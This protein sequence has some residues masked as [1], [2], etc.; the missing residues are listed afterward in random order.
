MWGTPDLELQEQVRERQRITIANYTN[1]PDLL[2]E[3]VGM[4]DNFQAGGYGERQIEELLQNAIDRLVEP[5]R[6]EFRLANSTLYC[7]N[8]GEPFAAAG[9]RAVTGAFLS[10]KRDEQIGRFGL[11]FKSV[12]GVTDHPQI[13]SR[14]VSFGFNEPEAAELFS[15]LPYRP[16]RVPT[17][18]VPSVIDARASAAEDPN[19]A[20]MM[21]WATTIVRLPL[22]RGGVRLRER[23]KGFDYRYL[24]F[25]DRLNQVVISLGERGEVV[26]RSYRKTVDLDAGLVTLNTPDGDDGVWRV[27]HREHDISRGVKANLP[28]LFHRDRVR[29][30]YALPV[31]Q[32]RREDGE[33]WAWFPLLDKTTAQGIFNAPWQV[34]DDRTSLLPRSELNGEMLEVA[35]ELLIDAATLE[36]TT[37]DPAKHF[38]VLPARGREV[39][40]AAD[41]YMSGRV[42]RLAR[43]HQLIPTASGEM[44]SPARVRAPFV[45]N[46]NG[47]RSFALP[48]EAIR[49]WSEATEAIDTPH[50]SCYQ[51]PTRAAR[52]TQLLSDED[53]KLSATPIAP[54]AWLAEA[55]APRTREAVDAALTIFLKLKEQQEQIWRQFTGALVVPLGSGSM[56]RISDLDKILLPV[57]GVPSPNVQLVAPTFASD[58]VI[59]GKLLRLGVHEVSRDQVAIAAAMAANTAWLDG[60]WKHFW[61]L[62]AQASPVAARTAIESIR[63]RRI[64]IRVP[65]TAGTWKPASQVFRDASQVP[66]LPERHVDLPG[67]MGRSDLLGLAGCLSG[68]VEDWPVHEGAVFEEYRAAMRAR[69]ERELAPEYGRNVRASVRFGARQGSGP[70]DILKEL[71]QIRTSE[72]DLARARL[73]AL[74]CTAMPQQQISVLVDVRGAHLPLKADFD[75]VE[76][77]CVRQYGLFDSTW[78]ARKSKDVLARA[79][80]E[81]GDLLP[82]LRESFAGHLTLP[83]RLDQIPTAILR[84]FL[85]RGGYVLGSEE[86]LGSVLGVAAARPELAG[87]AAI[88][89]LEIRSNLVQVTPI[90]QVVIAASDELEDLTSH[91]LRYI[92]SGPWDAV[93]SNAWGVQ[94]AADVIAR[95]TDWDAV[96]DAVPVPDVYPTL[97]RVLPSGS[98]VDDVMLRR[99]SSIVRRTTSPTGS[100]EQ[101]LSGHVDGHTVLVDADLSDVDA[102]VEVS[103]LLRLGLTRTDA[104]GVIARDERMRKNALVQRVQAAPTESAKL[105]VLVGRAGLVANLPDGLLD[106]IEGKQGQQPESAVADLFLSTYGNDSLRRLK[107]AIAARELAV[108]RAWDGSSE[109]D[110]FVTNLGFARAFAGIREKKAPTV[111]IVPGKVE[112]EP[113]HDFQ[114]DLLSQIRELVLIREKD[115]DHR[116]G[117]LYLPTGA[118]KTRVTTESIA[119]M[120]RDD[121]LAAPVLWIAQSEE[122]CEQ[123]IVTWT[124]VWRAIGDERPLEITRY[125]DSH[126]ADESLQELQVVVATD[127]KLAQMI[128]S[129]VNRQAHRWLQDAKLVVI[130]EAHRAGSQRYT[131]LLDWL[132]IDQRRGSHTA[133]P[134]LGLTA[135]PYR[136]TNPEVNRL[137]A[138]RFGDR[139]L[140]ALDPAKP[141]EQLREMRVLSNVEHQLLDSNVKISDDPTI[142]KTGAVAWDDVSRAILDKLGSN[143]DRTQLLVD[144]ILRQDPEWPIL[145]FTPSVVS[146]HVTAALLRSLDRPAEAV[147]GK[148]RGQERRRKIESFKHGRTKVLVNCDLLTQGF[149]AP[150]VRALYIARPTFSPNRYVQMVGRGLRGP[151]NGGTEECLIVN[152]VDTFEQFDRELAYTEFDYLWTKKGVGAK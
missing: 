43:R 48:A 99:C 26:S 53:G 70:L 116:R 121:E 5:G 31:G 100:R 138:Q 118:G 11:G 3:H 65:T 25:P 139:R 131:K 59:R 14:T 83:S 101:R 58:P 85:E 95:S 27:L 13:L 9:V 90:N 124:E 82:V 87:V 105:L 32:S 68:V 144:H 21:E 77:W 88:P 40:S 17:L 78:G 79:L 66:G 84:E 34:N 135:T 69:L 150:K 1:D 4:E 55:A 140:D 8:E 130:D 37:T 42:P 122:L 111:D 74:I 112:L 51:T 104:E 149:D 137:F 146:A 71:A 114:K 52:L 29:V 134:L 97:G 143:L 89:A 103:R 98:T 123:A 10:P 46:A 80:I 33:F 57:E 106:I 126:E 136:G 41:A 2:E 20:E 38:D 54:A 63:Q 107:G 56:A 113:L 15:D 110:A 35:A 49:L 67:V 117:L 19:V 125:W 96:G 141:I 60:D 142:G 102:L 91:G 129:T 86:L 128:D 148:M 36:S 7:A 127:A 108:P 73:T 16:A 30:S 61:E 62:L 92:P 44:R 133:R 23:L 6:V 45:A 120:L 132:G 81:Y 152:V 147:D 93:L 76:T 109:A 47:D 94:T 22:V 28:G 64:E 151:K 50:W 145:V 39:R 119:R 75:A 72:A 18:R 24:L 115:G 12:L